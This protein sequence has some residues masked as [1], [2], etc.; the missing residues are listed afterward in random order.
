VNHGK[1][2]T[3]EASVACGPVHA[4]TTRTASTRLQSLGKL[5]TVLGVTVDAPR[6]KSR[7][8]RHDASNER[9]HHAALRISASGNSNVFIYARTRT[10][11]GGRR[12]NHVRQM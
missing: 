5:A 9:T 3:T 4:E 12:I 2:R 11:A 6:W 8:V 7:H 1:P 10:V